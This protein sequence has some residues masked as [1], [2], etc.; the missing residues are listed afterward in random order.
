MKEFNLQISN[1]ECKIPL[2]N[3]KFSEKIIEY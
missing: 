2:K 3:E 1:L